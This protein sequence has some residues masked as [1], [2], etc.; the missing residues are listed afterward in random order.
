M[1]GFCKQE[2]LFYFLIDDSMLSPI[3]CYNS[4]MNGRLI[5]HSDLNN[6]YAS[7]ECALNP[8]L[9]NV[10]LA[11]S[12]DPEKRHG[13]ILAKNAI[14]K[15]AGVKTGDV[16]WEATQKC[17]DLKLVRPHFD[18]YM[19]FSRRVFD[20]YTRFTPSV[21][22][23]GP[24]EC[25]LD[26]T[27]C[28]SLFGSGEQIAQKIL[29]TIHQETGLT[30][31]I[32]I[33]FTKPLAKL[34]SD[35]AE[36]NGYFIATRADFREKLYRL[37]VADLL[38]VGKKTAAKLERLN[39]HTIGELADA[40]DAC[41]KKLLGINGLKIKQYALGEDDDN[42]RQYDKKRRA[43]SVGHGM[44]ASRDICNYDELCALFTF[45]SDKVSARMMKSGKKGY[46]IHVNL[47]SNDLIHKSK[48][49]KLRR[50]VFSSDDIR[51][52]AMRLARDILGDA[53]FSLRSVTVSVFDLVDENSGTQL[54]LFD[55]QKSD[56]RDSLAK[57]LE[58][59]SQK[60]GTGAVTRAN[61]FGQ[62]FIYDKTDDEDF[63]PFMR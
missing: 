36:P 34:G 22:S 48:Q 39:I 58:R 52:S 12:G 17:P 32:G 57:A 18:L 31:S 54:S 8:T 16:I 27:G 60:Y 47:R 41:L 35:L 33:S 28:T 56:E 1:Q 40:N 30:A 3:I 50:A 10:P 19:Q 6:F 24:D 53:P 49:L 51:E 43:E 38:M 20:I 29:N 45:L 63:L 15:A 21:E 25:W 61:L 62:D 23:F 7:V 13:V 2:N 42:V 59:I 37:P 5:L 11:V 46:G 26:C 44:T 55:T 4:D 14:A 9:R